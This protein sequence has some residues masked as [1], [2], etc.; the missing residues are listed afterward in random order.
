MEGPS[1]FRRASFRF[2]SC[3][4]WG[5]WIEWHVLKLDFK[6]KVTKKV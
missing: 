6:P 1:F 5:F 4:L 3:F 2:F